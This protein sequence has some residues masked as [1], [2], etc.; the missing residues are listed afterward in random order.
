MT[1]PYANE[2]TQVVTHDNSPIATLEKK[3][4]QVSFDEYRH[5]SVKNN[6]VMVSM[7]DID[8]SATASGLITSAPSK[9]GKKQEANLCGVVVAVGSGGYTADGKMI[10]PEY[11]I[12]DV[13][14]F[15]AASGVDFKIIRDFDTNKF[16]EVKI[17]DCAS[18]YYADGHGH[19]YYQGS[20]SADAK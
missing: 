8:F 3:R 9:D 1:H 13:V 4:K 18:V 10:K 17:V 5:L 16:E 14:F 15:S 11:E 20:D 19:L 6:R 12:G 7:I 2:N